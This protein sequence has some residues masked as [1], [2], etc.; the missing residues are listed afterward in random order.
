M[1]EKKSNKEYT[2]PWDKRSNNLSKKKH[3]SKDK[4][5][6]KITSEEIALATKKYLEEG[7]II[8]HIISEDKDLDIHEKDNTFFI[9]E[10]SW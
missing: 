5:S 1:E 10:G 9:E 2:H 3:I 4:S 6:Y 8:T 7:G